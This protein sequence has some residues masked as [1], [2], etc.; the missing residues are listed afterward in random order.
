MKSKILLFLSVFW[1]SWQF[2]GQCWSSPCTYCPIVD[3]VKTNY[4]SSTPTVRV[5]GHADYSGYDLSYI[6]SYL[7]ANNVVSINI[8]WKYCVNGFIGTNTYYDI[9]EDISF[10]HPQEFDIRIN[11]IMDTSTT[12]TNSNGCTTYDVL[13]TC[14]MSTYFFPYGYNVSLSE[15][16][17]ESI[18][19]S[20]NPARDEIHVQMTE[21][22]QIQQLVLQD[23]TGKEVKRVVGNV[24]KMDVYELSPGTYFLLIRTKRWV[25][26]KKVMIE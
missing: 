17:E 7:D 18:S 4:F 9:T 12:G 21:A 24:S 5:Y 13:D 15:L 25:F 8:F 11:N 23:I 14:L 19:V 3:S 2:Y 10:P 6:D 22:E 26:R 20:P 1:S 16:T